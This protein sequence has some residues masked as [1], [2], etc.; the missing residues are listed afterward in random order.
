MI[1]LGAK[2]LLGKHEVLKDI[3]AELRKQKVDNNLICGLASVNKFLWE[4][5]TLAKLEVDEN[6][7]YVNSKEDM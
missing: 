5:A 6:G 4:N 7:N 1:K 3:I 2:Q